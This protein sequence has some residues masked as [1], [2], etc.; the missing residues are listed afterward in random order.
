MS[1][2]GQ[3]I[4]TGSRC[5]SSSGSIYYSQ[6]YGATCQ[7]AGTSQGGV[8]V[9][10]IASDATGQYLSFASKNNMYRSTDYGFTWMMVATYSVTFLAS[11]AD[12]QVLYGLGPSTVGYKSINAG[13][14]WTA[15]SLPSL[16]SNVQY[17]SLSC[18]SAGQTVFV[19][20]FPGLVYKSSDYGVTWVSLNISE[21]AAVVEAFQPT[22]QPTISIRP[23]AT[24]TNTPQPTIHPTVRPTIAPSTRRPSSAQ[25]S[26]PT[27][28]PTVR[29]NAQFT[30]NNISNVETIRNCPTINHP[31]N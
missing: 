28:S 16:N 27:H 3:N 29:R 12:G 7:S 25:P 20:S 10:S 8:A 6:D 4:A 26:S 21:N 2:N 14:N 19:T 13:R 15:L 9:Y 5:S 17:S 23:S 11:S 31:F 22:M 18:D 1:S 24:P 30:S